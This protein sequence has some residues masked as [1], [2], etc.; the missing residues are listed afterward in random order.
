MFESSWDFQWILPQY[1][2]KKEYTFR[3]RVVYRERCN[4]TEVVREYET[5]RKNLL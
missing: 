1:D 4:R 5:W 3:A 2:V